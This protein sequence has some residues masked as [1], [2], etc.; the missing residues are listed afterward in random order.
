MF[1]K[2][3]VEKGLISEAQMFEAL[4]KQGGMR[5][6]IGRLAFE[7]ELLDMDQVCE[8]LDH[9]RESQLRFAALGVELGLLKPEQRDALLDAQAE[10]QVPLGQVLAS[11]AVVSAERL[12]E[13]LEIYEQQKADGLWPKA[14]T[15]GSPGEGRAGPAA[16]GDES[17]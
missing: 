4:E 15:S 12:A 7:L 11:M 16:E 14:P 1:G 6:S 5:V 17:S 3:L 10:T 9:Q 8:I 13:E 2:Y